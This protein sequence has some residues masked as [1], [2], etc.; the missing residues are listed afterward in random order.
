MPNYDDAYVLKVVSCQPW[1]DGQ[2]NLILE[3]HLGVALKTEAT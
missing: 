3:E 2:V 1:Q